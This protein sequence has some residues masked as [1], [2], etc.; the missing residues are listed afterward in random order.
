MT[1]HIHPPEACPVH[2]EPITVEGACVRVSDVGD[3]M[4]LHDAGF[5][6][7]AFASGE[8]ASVV[9]AKDKGFEHLTAQ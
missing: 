2:D 7:A 8:W 9:P 3:L 4:I 6:I 1:F 5:A